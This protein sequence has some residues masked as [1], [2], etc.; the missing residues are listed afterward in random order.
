PVQEK[1]M[2]HTKHNGAGAPEELQQL[3]VTPESR[4]FAS[5]H[6]FSNYPQQ[7]NFASSHPIVLFTF[8]LLKEVTAI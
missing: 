4:W 5:S 8:Y 7:L 6:T 2:G 1:E 3:T